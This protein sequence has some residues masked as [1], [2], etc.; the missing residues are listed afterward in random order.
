MDLP[1]PQVL[2]MH[3]SAREDAAKTLNLMNSSTNEIAEHCEHDTSSV[4]K[5]NGLKAQ[6]E[7]IEFSIVNFQ[8]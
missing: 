6:H 7:V 2:D 4:T 3:H 5:A 1:P 8:L